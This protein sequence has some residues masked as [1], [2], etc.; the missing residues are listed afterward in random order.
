[1]FIETSAKAGYNVKQVSSLLYS[2]HCS[3]QHYVIK[4]VSYIVAFSFI[5][6]RKSEYPEITTDLS[7]TLS[8]YVVSSTGQEKTT[9]LS[10][11]TNTFNNITV[12]P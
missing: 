12:I 2:C 1:M 8:H 5:A 4:F 6:G 7:Q 10:Q 3:I 9:N 11:V